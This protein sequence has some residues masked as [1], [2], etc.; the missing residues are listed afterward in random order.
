M[1]LT[2]RFLKY[3]AVPTSSDDKSTTVPTAEKEFVLAKMLVEDMREIGYRGC[4]CRR[5][6]LRL[7]TYSRDGRIREQEENRL[8][9]AHRHLSRLCGARR[10]SRRIIKNYDGG[11]VVLG[12]S[13]RVLEVAAF[14]HLKKLTGRTLITTDGN[15][16]LGA[17]GATK[18][19]VSEILYAA[20]EKLIKSGIPSRTYFD[21]VH[22]RRGMRNICRHTKLTFP[23]STRSLLTL[24][25]AE[26]RER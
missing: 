16:L 25:T 18:S 24:S 10:L 2:E 17:D 20:E 5:Q 21:C 6:M 23:H 13:G 14:P 19:G 8:Y 11:D 12:D 3:V 9:L 4:L 22:T 1:E 26:P 15:T 7:R